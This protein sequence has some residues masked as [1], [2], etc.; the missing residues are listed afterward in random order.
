MT[1]LD[2]AGLMRAGLGELRLPPE[3]FWRLTPIELRIMLGVDAVQPPLTRARL[4]E[5]A[6]AFPDYS[7]T[8]RK[9]SE[10]DDSPRASGSDHSA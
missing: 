3:V 1:G 6:A 10:N 5:L 9:G 7:A 4:E 8:Q 2:W